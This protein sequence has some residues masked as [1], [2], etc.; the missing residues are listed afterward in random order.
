MSLRKAA[1][2][3]CLQL[4]AVFLG[5]GFPRVQDGSRARMKEVTVGGETSRWAVCVVSPSG[6]QQGHF[7]CLVRARHG[8]PLGVGGLGVFVPQHQVIFF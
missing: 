6:I 8:P 2:W 4:E 5:A 1:K 3:S 7:S